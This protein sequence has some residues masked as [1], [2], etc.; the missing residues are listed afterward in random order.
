MPLLMY[1][2]L[3]YLFL[4]S[5]LPTQTWS[6]FSTLIL[7]YFGHLKF[8]VYAKTCFYTS[9]MKFN[10]R[11]TKE[12]RL[13]LI[14]SCNETFFFSFLFIQMTFPSTPSLANF[15]LL[16]HFPLLLLKTISIKLK[17]NSTNLRIVVTTS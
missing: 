3:I 10:I 6:A 5:S 16:R 15:D 17:T 7:D 12:R 4:L 9:A 13:F 14:S 2:V 11:N 1:L 8:F